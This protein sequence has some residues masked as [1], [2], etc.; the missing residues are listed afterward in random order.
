M[1][2]PIMFFTFIIVVLTQHDVR[3]VPVYKTILSEF[4]IPNSRYYH[5]RLDNIEGVGLK[6]SHFIT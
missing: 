2:Y 3:D 5:N 6:E 4:L 1:Y